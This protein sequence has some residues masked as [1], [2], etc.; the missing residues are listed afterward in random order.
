M[1]PLSLLCAPEELVPPTLIWPPQA[2]EVGEPGPTLDP[3]FFRWGMISCIPELYKVRFTKDPDWGIYRLGFTEGATAWP[4]QDAQY[5]EMGLEPASEYF[6]EVLAWTDGVN[7]PASVQRIFFTGPSCTHIGDLSPPVLLSPGDGAVI[8]GL[9]LTLHYEP[10]ENGCIPDGYYIDLQTAAD[11]SGTSLYDQE[12]SSKHTFFN[13]SGLSDCTTYYVRVAQIED[14]IL[15][16]FSESLSFFTNT[17]GICAQSLTPQFKAASDLPCYQGPVP[18][19]YPVLGYL[20]Q[21]EMAS[22]V[23]QSLDQAK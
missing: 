12:W 1:S 20:L 7:G 16:P 3:E 17:S 11:F 19:T 18:G 14:Q 10:G 8:P 13:V 15:G 4:P 21:G 22:I 6:W 5:P 23:A 2:A 9:E